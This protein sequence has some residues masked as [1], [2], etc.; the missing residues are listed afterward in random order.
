[1]ATM[2]RLAAL[3]CASLVTGALADGPQIYRCAAA[4]KVT[5]QEIP[6][7][8]A[9]D[10][11]AWAVPAF[12]PVNVVE[13]ERLLQREAA[14]DARLV[15]RAEID[16]QERIAREQ[17]RAREAEVEAERERARAAEQAVF[18]PAYPAFYPRPTPHHRHRPYRGIW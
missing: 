17:R 12:P 8:G 9:A 4:G 7:A 13:R 3:F 16:A 2:R 6:C 5:F 10:E 14:L 11:R 1:M 15:R 18:Y